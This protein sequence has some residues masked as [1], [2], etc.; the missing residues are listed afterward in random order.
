MSILDYLDFLVLLLLLDFL[1]FFDFL[2]F[3]LAFAFLPVLA[4]LIGVQPAILRSLAS[5]S[6]CCSDEAPA[7]ACETRGT[8]ILRSDRIYQ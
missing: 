2:L 7:L 3:L 6:A 4:D 1:L 8:L 5:T